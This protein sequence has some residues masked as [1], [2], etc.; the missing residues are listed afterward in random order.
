MCVVVVVGGGGG[1]AEIEIEIERERERGRMIYGISR[2]SGQLFIA[3]LG[4]MVYIGC[5]ISI[6]LSGPEWGVAI[7]VA[8]VCAREKGLVTI[9]RFLVARTS[10]QVT[11]MYI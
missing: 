10:M 8:R 9:A 6:S 3:N 4:G 5:D 1:G 7:I 11:Y 2:A